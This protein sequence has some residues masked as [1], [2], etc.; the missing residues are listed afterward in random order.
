MSTK[1]AR[2][3]NRTHSKAARLAELRGIPIANAVDLLLEGEAGVETD[4]VATPV[5]VETPRNRA[6]RQAPEPVDPEQFRLPTELAEQQ[7]QIE[8]RLERLE[9]ST[10]H[11]AEG[12]REG[13]GRYFRESLAWPA[14]WTV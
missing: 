2:L 13:S 14:A 11:L 5:Q 4:P 1:P 8:G 12:Q 10:G 7:R 3:S 9:E 6:E